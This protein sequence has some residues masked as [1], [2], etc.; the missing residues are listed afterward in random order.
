[1][2]AR[3]DPLEEGSP[4]QQGREPGENGHVEAHAGSYAVCV[5]TCDGSFFPVSYSGAG[6]R[7]DSLEEVCR[8]L[9]PNADMALYSFPFGGT[10]DEAESASGEPYADLPN[11]GK[12]QQTNDPA[13]SCRRRG[14]SWAE[15][16]ADAEA[17]YGHE[18]HDIIVTP[19]KSAEMARPIVDPKA[20][21]VIDPKA[22]PGA[23]GASVVAGPGAAPAAVPGAT[24]PVDAPTAPVLDINGADTKLSAATATV[25]RE[26]SGIAGDDVQGAKSFSVNQG[27]TVEVTGPDGVK[28]LVRIVGPPL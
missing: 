1:M 6:S 23:P 16:L 10:I 7:S 24:P 8:A 25:S 21:L 9:C 15:A 13:C 22:K 26:A 27:R 4:N 28:R 2:D 5:R 11:A 19:E 14:E 18:K 3:F 20:K 17:R 12:F